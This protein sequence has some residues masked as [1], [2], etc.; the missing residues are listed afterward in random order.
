MNRGVLMKKFNRKALSI[1]IVISPL[2]LPS[3][4]AFATLGNKHISTNL[5]SVSNRLRDFKPANKFITSSLK[6]MVSKPSGDVSKSK[7]SHSYLKEAI[8][9]FNND[10]DKFNSNL[11][12]SPKLLSLD[13]SISNI[14]SKK[15]HL[16]G[17]TMVEDT[18]E[19]VPNIRVVPESERVPNIVGGKITR[20]GFLG[21]NSGD[22][23][24]YNLTSV[25]NKSD[26]KFEEHSNEFL[27]DIQNS[28][29]TMIKTF[30]NVFSDYSS[31]D[32]TNQEKSLFSLSRAYSSKLG[33]KSLKNDDLIGG[34]TSSKNAHT[35]FKSEMI[36][37]ND[38]FVGWVKQK[39]NEILTDTDRN[40]LMRTL[41]SIWIKNNKE[42]ARSKLKLFIPSPSDK[43]AKFSI[44]SPEISSS[45]EN[46]DSIKSPSTSSTNSYRFI[47]TSENNLDT[48]SEVDGSK[49][50]SV[51]NKSL[52]SSNLKKVS[53]NNSLDD[54]IAGSLS[55]EDEGVFS[56]TSILGIKSPVND[57]LELHGKG[58][59]KVPGTDSYLEKLVYKHDD[60]NGFSNLYVKEN[61]KLS[62]V[63][64][65]TPGFYS[66]VISDDQRTIYDGIKR[67]AIV[68]AKNRAG[69]SKKV[70]I[71]SL[72]LDDKGTEGIY[73][74]QLDQGL[75]RE[76]ILSQN[77]TY[78]LEDVVKY[79]NFGAN[80]QGKLRKFAKLYNQFFSYGTP[81][82]NVVGNITRTTSGILK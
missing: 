13:E 16:D 43:I 49:I 32:L 58:Y 7:S 28:Q 44:S 12:K 82:V 76:V 79:E 54:N 21:N 9:L 15:L 60:E 29:N 27:N 37:A 51:V 31:D 2:S 46:G 57:Q 45:E 69:E 1:G 14:A 30:P 23:G 22:N 72:I 66:Y 50:T 35:L 73:A 61:G 80:V 38:D 81:L 47:Y 78:Y 64:E 48:I 77:G 34:K 5:N 70:V 59:M 8:D 36:V 11:A 71:Q 41:D 25:K 40:E 74:Y 6:R 39:S 63:V 3:I 55:P 75:W 33:I 20:K 56:L 65:T 4:T 67:G 42:S 26:I 52:Y 19:I 10:K 62:K 68:D 18:G 53:T 17:Y 24:R